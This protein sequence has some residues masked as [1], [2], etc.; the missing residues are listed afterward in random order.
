MKFN[1]I[2]FTLAIAGSMFLA[3]C[4]GGKPD[5][6]A[7]AEMTAF[8]GNWMAAVESMKAGAGEIKMTCDMSKSA[9][10]SACNGECKK[11]M[12]GEC[13]SIKGGCKAIQENLDAMGAAA[14]EKI[15]A[16]DAD[17]KAWAEWKEKV[18]KGEVKAEDFK[19]GMEDWNMKISEINASVT[20][21]KSKAEEAKTNCMANCEKM[22]SCCETKEA[23]KK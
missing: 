23:V 1:K 17:G 10:D 5:E 7:L 11:D 2:L 3:A 22:K 15:A 21:W 18:M 20:E 8:E 9:T 4:G 13:D 14:A 19:K 12:K 6:A 16:A